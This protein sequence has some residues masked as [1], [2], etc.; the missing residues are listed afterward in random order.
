VQKR[1]FLLIC[2]AFVLPAPAAAE[3]ATIVSRDVPLG[4]QRSLAAN[5][6]VARFNLVGL[7][8]RGPGAVQFRTRSLAGR[9]NGWMD[10]APEDEDQ[11]DM[12]TDERARLAAW[13]LG[14]PWWVGP[15]D[16]IEYRLRGKVTRLRAHFVWSPQAGVPARTLQMAGVPPIVP[17]SGWNADETIRRSTPSFAPVIR[18]AVVHHTAGANG[19]TAAQSPSIVRA[20]QLYHVKGNGWND[21][22]YNFLVDRFGTVFEGRYG[23]IDR[24][25]VGAHAEGFNTG[26]VG[27]SVLGEYSSLLA[28]PQARQS[29]A[30]LLAWRLDLA[31]VDPAS[32][33]SYISGGNARYPAGLPVFLRTVSGHRDVGF[34]DCPGTALY[35]LLNGIT[36]EVATIGLPKLYAPVVTGT[37]P[38]AVRITA[39]LS[40]ALPWMIE[41]RDVAGNAVASTSGLG[42]NIDWSWDAT[43]LPPGSYSY[44]IRSEGSVTPATGAIGAIGG[45]GGATGATFS[46]SGLAAD[47]ETVSPNND[48]VADQTT[49]TYTLT[50]AGNVTV[51]LRDELGNELATL[52]NKAWKRAGE[53]AIR[54]DPV[55]LPDGLFQIEV[56]AIATGG[57][58]A[59]ASTQIAVSR[60]LG[61]VT[62]ARLAFSP[63]ADGLADRIGFNFELAAPAQIRLRILKQGKWVA[64]PFAGALEPGPQRVE[65][66]GAKRVGRLL[67]GEYEAV[68]EAIDAFATTTV[69][70]PFSSDTRAPRVRIVQRSPLRL[71]VSEPATVTMRF[72]AR[73]LVYQALVLGEARVLKAP[74]LGL[75]RAV[76]WDAAGNKSKP[77]SRR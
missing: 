3:D 49:I 34:S 70:V 1:L 52:A 68:V 65:W 43:L 32:T 53:H 74:R 66:D 24:N 27:V 45:G 41:V 28:S 17:R 56:S 57:R 18:L 40:S 69:A 6:P 39:R 26:S 77:A 51:K 29:L 20:I 4:S 38:G 14:N 73:R 67:D 35:N 48:T 8:W 25:V 15:S 61:K 16:R 59:T 62:A 37:V 12:G 60:T 55:A 46:V 76:A 22:G 5:E 36:G 44:S 10:A 47:P 9:W 11:P 63:N 2:L 58:Q 42:S 71:W 54:F 64:T 33:L 72:G 50:D 23:G 13:R 7:H 31:H 75:V 19:Y 21:I 30:S